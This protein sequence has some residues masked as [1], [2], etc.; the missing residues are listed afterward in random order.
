MTSMV[1]LMRMPY[2]VRIILALTIVG[3]IIAAIAIVVRLSHGWALVVFAILAVAHW[4]RQGRA[5]PA[6]VLGST[7][8]V[9]LY[10]TRTD[11]ESPTTLQSTAR[12]TGN[13]EIL[14]RIAAHARHFRYGRCFKGFAILAHITLEDGRDL[15]L[16]L[17]VVACGFTIDGERGFYLI[18]KS[19]I[20]E[21]DNMVHST[22]TNEFILPHIRN[23][24]KSM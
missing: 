20:A 4:V 5:L 12:V 2:A 6:S 11:R 9:V 8:S 17:C 3:A 22:I 19:D 15:Y 21:W 7:K 10:H 23:E 24:S 1:F 18:R 14:R 16:R 13:P